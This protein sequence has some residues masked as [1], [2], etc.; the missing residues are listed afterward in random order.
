MVKSQGFFFSVKT[1]PCGVRV[2]TIGPTSRCPA[3]LPPRGFREFARS[4]N[5]TSS[6]KARRKQG[7][8]KGVVILMWIVVHLI[9]YTYYVIIYM[10]LSLSTYIAKSKS[11]YMHLKFLKKCIYQSKSISTCTYVRLYI[12][13]K[14]YLS[15]SLTTYLPINLSIYLSI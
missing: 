14:N 8:I 9:K 7:K 13:K 5:A 6:S 15:L 3:V 4:Q 2:C 11:S 10:F 1:M 12:W